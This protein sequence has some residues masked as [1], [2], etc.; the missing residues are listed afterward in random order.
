MIKLNERD[1][2]TN[3]EKEIDSVLEKISKLDPSSEGY[4]N[5]VESLEKL[6]KAKSYDKSKTVSY[7]TLAVVIGNL[8]GIG[9]ILGYEQSR[10]ITSKALNFVLRGRV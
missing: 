6:Y 3:L 5:A 4:K 8:A 10:V 7:D 9:M 1:K 2:R